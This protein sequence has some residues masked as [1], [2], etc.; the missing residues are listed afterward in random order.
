MNKDK[1]N[2][3]DGNTKI[4]KD[5]VENDLLKIKQLIN[6]VNEKLNCESNEI[7][8]NTFKYIEHVIE[9]RLESIKI[10]II[11][12]C[13]QCAFQYWQKSLFH[14]NHFKYSILSYFQ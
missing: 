10:K 14:V 3:N 7:I 2:Q 13:F 12:V 1:E 11:C 8:E 5:A 9:V 6:R 4:S